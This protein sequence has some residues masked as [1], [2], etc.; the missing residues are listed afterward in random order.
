[1][2]A[3]DT[4]LPPAAR[5]TDSKR[6]ADGE[7]EKFLSDNL[8]LVHSLAHRYT[9]RGVE[10]DDLYSAG[11]V[12]LIKA[13]DGFD[14]SKGCSFS[15]YA[16]PVI[17]GEIKRIFRDGGAVKVS[18]TLKELAGRLGRERARLEAEMG[19]E[20]T[21]SELASR[22][23]VTPEEVTEALDACVSPMSLTVCDD[24]GEH[25]LDIPVSGGEEKMI[26]KIALDQAIGELCDSD[27]KIITLRYYHDMTQ[28]QTAKIMGITQVAVSRREKVILA[29]LK[30]MLN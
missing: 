13:Y 30:T 8:L 23:N 9:G 21:V 14:K 26:D 25:T 2:A 4:N 24:S 1:M 18:R 17:L 11:C 6:K 27:R 28:S 3:V 10:Y 5:Q 29:H 19:R 15:T 20:P 16:V 7:R 22:L 12:G